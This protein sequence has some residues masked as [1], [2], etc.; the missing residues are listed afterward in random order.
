MNLEHL[1]FQ[2]GLKDV[3][4]RK[5]QIVAALTILPSIIL[6]GIFVYGFIGNSVY[7]STTDWGQSA[8]MAL[9]P[10][11]EG[12]GLENYRELFTGFLNVRFGEIWPTC[13]SSQSS[14]SP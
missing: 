14:L 9:D 1:I 13:F 12:V 10:Q 6:L 5:D 3:Q 7:M 4:S 8:A 2:K 11:I